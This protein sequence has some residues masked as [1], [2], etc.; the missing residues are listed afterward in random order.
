MKQSRD[1]YLF[2]NEVNLNAYI[3]RT[4]L[5]VSIWSTKGENPDVSDGMTSGNCVVI[6]T[7]YELENDQLLSKFVS[8]IGLLI[9]TIIQPI[10][11]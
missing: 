9:T 5:M 2:F 10:S 4:V 1:C 8:C 3:V 6:T 7:L 11:E